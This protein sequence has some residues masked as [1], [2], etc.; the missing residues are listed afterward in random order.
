MKNSNTVNPS[1][2]DERTGISMIRPDG[3]AIRPRIPANCV[4]FDALPRAPE[5]LIM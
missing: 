4:K 2:N 1:L 5:S 3:D